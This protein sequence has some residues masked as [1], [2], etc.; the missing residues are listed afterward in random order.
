MKTKNRD[1]MSP[2]FLSSILGLDTSTAGEEEGGVIRC[3]P[4]GITSNK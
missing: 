3:I 1:I 2:T 4:K